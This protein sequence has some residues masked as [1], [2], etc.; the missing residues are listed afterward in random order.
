[1]RGSALDD[2]ATH[3]PVREVFEALQHPRVV[4]DDN[5]RPVLEWLEALGERTADA[6]QIAID[7]P[8]EPGPEL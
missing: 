4:A 2:L 8:Q 3:A 5:H 1:V 6:P 7:V